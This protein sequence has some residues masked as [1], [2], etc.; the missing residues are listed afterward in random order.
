[1]GRSTLGVGD[2]ELMTPPRPLRRASI[3]FATGAIAVGAQR[4]DVLTKSGGP[5]VLWGPVAVG[6]LATLAGGLA[7]GT[8]AYW[9]GH[10]ELVDYNNRA[11]QATSAAKRS[12]D[13]VAALWLVADMQRALVGSTHHSVTENI[14]RFVK[15]TIMSLTDALRLIHTEGDGGFRVTFMAFTQSDDKDSNRGF[16][17]AAVEGVSADLIVHF[18]D[19]IGFRQEAMLLMSEMEPGYRFGRSEDSSQSVERLRLPGEPQEMLRVAVCASD[20]KAGLL[21]IDAWGK[22]LHLDEDVKIIRTFSNLLAT[23]HAVAQ[24]VEGET[25]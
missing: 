11:Q 25:Q 22:N 9:T 19:H 3:V 8:I 14:H 10:K 5:P 21:M 4:F 12:T 24:L 1:M 2:V 23:G 13:I 7:T 6:F 15:Y 17:C 16:V 20:V 18:E